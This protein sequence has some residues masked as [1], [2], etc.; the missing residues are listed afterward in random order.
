LM[1]VARSMVSWERR[2]VATGRTFRKAS[3]ERRS[4]SIVDSWFS[5]STM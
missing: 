3:L 5:G 1:A 2:Q 4:S